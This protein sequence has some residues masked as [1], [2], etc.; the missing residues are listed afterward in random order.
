MPR[1]GS[2][3]WPS[4]FPGSCFENCSLTGSPE[5]LLHPQLSTMVSVQLEVREFLVH[6]FIQQ[7]LAEH[8]SRSLGGSHGV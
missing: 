6:S 3:P 4:G 1:G 2:A 8:S 7:I 5:K